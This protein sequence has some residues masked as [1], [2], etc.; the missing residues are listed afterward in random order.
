[1]C[2]SG[3][4]GHGAEEFH[5]GFGF[6]E[7]AEEKLHGFDG[8]GRAQ[9]LAEDSDAAEVAGGKQ[10]LVLARAGAPDINGGEDALIGEA[11]VEIDFRFVLHQRTFGCLIFIY[12]CA[13]LNATSPLRRYTSR[14]EE[15]KPPFQFNFNTSLK[16][17]FQGLRVTSGG[18]LIPVRE[19]DDR[20]GFSE[21][22]EQR[23]TKTRR[24][25]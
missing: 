23:L 14:G 24:E 4:G 11:A 22:I 20:L 8:G 10:E 13:G 15:T 19:L 9:A 18:D 16:V 5:V 1:L 21:L 3:E 7:A 17:D 2:S 12:I 6:G 25:Q